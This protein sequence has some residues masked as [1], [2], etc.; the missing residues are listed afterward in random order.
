MYFLI[1]LKKMHGKF[2]GYSWNIQ[3]IFVNSMF[4]EHYFGNIPRNFIGYFLRIFREYIMGMFHEYSTNIHLPGGYRF[5]GYPANFHIIPGHLN[6][7][8]PFHAT[9]FFLYPLKLRENLWFRKQRVCKTREYK[10]R[11]VT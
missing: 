7:I 8:N 2:I 6:T 4:S 11:P 9:I 1:H 10:K 5:I 3:G